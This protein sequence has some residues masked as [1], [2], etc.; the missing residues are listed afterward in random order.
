MVERVAVP[1]RGIWG[2]M[3]FDWAQ[4]PFHTLIITFVFAPYFAASVAPDAARGQELWGLATGAGGLAIALS[5]PVLGAIAD[6][7]GPRKPWILAFSL[8]G[9][10]ACAGL[11]FAAPGM[12]TLGPV[13]ILIAL[14]VFGM[15]YAAVFN[16]AMMPNLVPRAELGRLSGSAWGLGYLGG[17]VSLVLV[18]GFMSASPET[19]RTLLGLEPIFGLDAAAREGDRAAGPLTALWYAVF[20]LPMLFFTPDQPRR[21]AVAGAVREGLGRLAQTIRRLPTE[22]SYFSFLLSSMFYRDALN[23]LY[24]F[25]GIYAAGVL[26]WSI[27]LIGL[28]GILANV[29]GALGAWAGGRMDQAF[30]PKAV[31]TLAILI[32]SACCLLVISTTRTEVFFIPLGGAG[33]SVPDIAFFVAGGFIGAAGGAI[34][35]ASRTLLV[36]Q[37]AR[38]RVTEAFGLY[39]L[40][41]KATTFIG[42]FAVAAATAY[43]SSAAFSLAP[44]DAQRLGV[45]PIL[46]LFAV[47]LALLPF[48]SS[49]QYQVAPG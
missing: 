48:V 34:Q 32:L 42:P 16:N 13:L 39:A 7:T 37:V 5:S 47:G 10:L 8:I 29:T 3:L 1:R 46:V 25:G 11:W 27:T 21:K 22:R 24:A 41:G 28:F 31:V 6:A 45:T 40:S 26:G 15:E 12:A 49:R 35:A 2:W 18:L 44:E 19:G 9:V 36:D 23:A 14:A 30:G 20:V 4:Q 38:E 17:L 43:F 33:S